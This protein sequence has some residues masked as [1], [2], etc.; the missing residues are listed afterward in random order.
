MAAHGRLYLASEQG[1]VIALK[2]GKKDKVLAVNDMGDEAFVASP[3]IANRRMYL[4]S[5]DELFCIAAN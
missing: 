3:I 2:L 5:E 4:R 1:D